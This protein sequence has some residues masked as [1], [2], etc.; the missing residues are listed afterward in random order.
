MGWFNIDYLKD[1]SFIKS[2]GGGN[3]YTAMGDV[4]SKFGGIINAERDRKYNIEQDRLKNERESK[5]VESEV[6]KNNSYVDYNDAGAFARMAQ[7]QKYISDAKQN[8][9]KTDGQIKHWNN[10]DAIGYGRLGEYKRHNL[11]TEEI[12]RSKSSGGNGGK[13]SVFDIGNIDIFG[14]ESPRQQ[15]KKEF[16]EK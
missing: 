1:P 14:G 9:R 7:G 11:N 16:K 10:T 3:A 15:V 2:A 5:K 12:Q 8:I 4:L 6:N 13:G